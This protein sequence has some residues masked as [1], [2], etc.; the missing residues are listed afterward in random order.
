MLVFDNKNKLRPVH[1]ILIIFWY[2]ITVS[3][4]KFLKTSVFGALLKEDLS[5]T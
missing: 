2:M 5:L 1:H 3:F 4:E